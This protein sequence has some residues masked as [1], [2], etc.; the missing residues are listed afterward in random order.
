MLA[1]RPWVVI[2]HCSHPRKRGDRRGGAGAPWFVRGCEQWRI[3]AQ[4]RNASITASHQD[5]LRPSEARLAGRR[6]I[7]N[8][9][10]NCPIITYTLGDT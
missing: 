8:R 10:L 4:G 9:C 2:R 1:F 5:P 6:A 3:T 7:A